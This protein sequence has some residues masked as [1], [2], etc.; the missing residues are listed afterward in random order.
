MFFVSITAANLFRLAA[1]TSIFPV[2]SLIS[3]A[4]VNSLCGLAFDCPYY[5]RQDDCP[6]K[7][8]EQLPKR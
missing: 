5:D 8:M 2:P 1:A 3:M 7:E 4:D 6:L